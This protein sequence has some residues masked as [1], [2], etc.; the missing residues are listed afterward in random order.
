MGPLCEYKEAFRGVV[1]PKGDGSGS[2]PAAVDGVYRYMVVGVVITNKPIDVGFCSSDYYLHGDI[3][4]GSLLGLL[5]SLPSHK[6]PFRFGNASNVLLSL[7]HL[8]P[9]EETKVSDEGF[10]PQGQTPEPPSKPKKKSRRK[11]S[12]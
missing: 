12:R 6:T 2:H 5:R 10:I 3:S 8:M 9:S 1:Y 11:G 7:G 4:G